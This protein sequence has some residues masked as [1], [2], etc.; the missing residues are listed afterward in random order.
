MKQIQ[1]QNQNQ[2]SKKSFEISKRQQVK[3]EIQAANKIRNV[4]GDEEIKQALRYVFTLIGL[5]PDQI[6]GDIEKVVLINYIKENMKS[7]TAAEIRIAFELAIK[8]DFKTE[9]NH[10]GHF[11]A[12]YLSRIFN[13]YVEHRRQIAFELRREEDEKDKLKEQ[14][15]Q[16]RPEVKAAHAKRF[17]QNVII[18]LFIQ[19]QEHKSFDLGLLPPSIIYKSLKE[20]HG[21][22]NFDK[23]EKDR[24]MI[25]AKQKTQS[26]VEHRLHRFGS[27]QD[28]DFRKLMKNAV[29]GEEKRSQMDQRNCHLIAIEELFQEIIDRN[30]HLKDRMK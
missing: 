18:P 6:P 2:I 9:L 22:F 29:K 25:K 24:I 8:G 16:N 19:Y 11:S 10:Y 1:T 23:N 21:L 26:E 28:N 5:K 13:D 7:Y 30:E 20:R 3:N 12:L 27:K 17:D 15:Y 14:E 4:E